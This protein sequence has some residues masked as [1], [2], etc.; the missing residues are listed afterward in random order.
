MYNW[1]NRGTEIAYPQWQT[2][3][4]WGMH[5]EGQ[6]IY[7]LLGI[8]VA[9]TFGLTR[10]GATVNPRAVQTEPV[11][12]P[13]P[14]STAL[15]AFPGAEGFGADTV[16]GRGG[17]VIAVTNLN[18][19]GPGSLRAAIAEEGPRIVV[20]QVGG[21]IELQS[22]ID[23]EHPYIT[24][25]GQTAPGDGITLKNHPSVIHSPLRILTHDV[26]IRY[27]RSRPG[28]SE[29]PSDV[30][31]ALTIADGYNIVI[32]HSSFSWGSDEVFNIWYDVHNVTIQWSIIAEGLHEST[33]PEGGHSNGMLIGSDGS[34]EISIHH[35]LFAHN[36]RRNPKVNMVGMAD[37]VNN[38]I[39]NARYAMMIQDTYASPAVNY[40]GNVVIHGVNSF[41]DYDVRYF[42]E[43]NNP[44][45]I[46]VQGNL[47]VKRP[48]D[49][50]A[51]YW[52][53]RL[54]DRE[55]LVDERIDA[56]Q[57]TTYQACASY[58]QVLAD[59]GV[60]IPLRDAVDERLVDDV[61]NRTGQLVNDP[62]EVGGWPELESG[63]APADQDNDGMPDTW[64][65]AH[66]LDPDDP[67]DGPLDADDDGYT[68]VEEYLNGLVAD[69]SSAW[70]FQ[71]TQSLTAPAV[72]PVRSTL[73]ANPFHIFLPSIFEQERIPNCDPSQ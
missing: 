55:Y 18:D 71:A 42:N 43:G 21:T 50:L 67:D 28:A 7:L 54:E 51:D 9:V 70:L 35:N 16:G 72:A 23:I 27:L 14:Q 59:A 47:G 46:Y 62:S 61:I 73:L 6:V 69:K 24:I 1:I 26:V 41:Y 48:T 17:K 11:A 40:V 44:P 30:L 4:M 10:S 38:V 39:Y 66:G 53:V 65:Q 31:D 2:R 20:F 56:P 49:D 8:V 52:V 13:L 19:S 32:D 58:Q 68:N 36:R 64:E 15:P 22:R 29:E 12:R 63:E 34:G 60:T 25:A 33:H 5:P 37:V 57:V 3:W 45:R